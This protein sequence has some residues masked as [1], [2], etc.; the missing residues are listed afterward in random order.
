[1][2]SFN[3]SGVNTLL[4]MAGIAIATKKLHA[5]RI[6][7]GINPRAIDYYRAILQF[8]PMG[9]K[10]A[11]AQLVAPVAGMELNLH[12][13]RPFLAR[14][15]TQAMASGFLPV[16]HFLGEL[17]DCISLPEGSHQE[18]VRW[19]LSREVFREVFMQHSNHLETLDAS[20]RQYLELQRTPR[21]IGQVLRPDVK[22]LRL[23]A[24]SR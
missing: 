2:E 21:T 3:C 15:Y 13:L 22:N 4:M 6:V 5:D 23:L 9:Q 11:H 20:T 17:P 14:A 10:K 1:M 24:S 12:A 19:K 16:E 18:L 8:A 7:I